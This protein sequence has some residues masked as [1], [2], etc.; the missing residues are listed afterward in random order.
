[1]SDDRPAE[2]ARGEEHLLDDLRDDLDRA[3]T[4]P[5]EERAAAY[6]DVHARLTSALDEPTAA[7]GGEPGVASDADGA[8]GTA[9]R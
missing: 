2:G 5:L 7:R 8:H 1:M 4:L 9:G 3:G 6:A